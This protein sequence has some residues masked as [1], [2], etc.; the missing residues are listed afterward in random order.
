MQ[1]SL[2]DKVLFKRENIEA[3]IV[4]INSMYKVRVLSKDGFE[5]NVSVKDLVKIEEGTDTIRSYGNKFLSK[6]TVSSLMKSKKQQKNQSNLKIDL[7]IELLRPNYK[8]LD[9]SEII[10]I[11]LNECYNTIEKALNSNITKIVI[12]H[13]IGEGVLKNEVH[14]ILTNYNLRFYLTK[15]G[16]ATEVYL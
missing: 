13:G 9:K 11:Q 14:D 10:Q 1:F 7:H 6:D 12:I 5:L 8:A 4:R 2:G 16:G 15:D 3:E